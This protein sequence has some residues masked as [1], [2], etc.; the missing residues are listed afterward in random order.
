MIIKGVLKDGRQLMQTHGGMVLET[1]EQMRER[2]AE[3]ARARVRDAAPE[4][5]AACEAVMRCAR[6]EIERP[7]TERQP[8]KEAEHLVKAAIAKAKGRG[9]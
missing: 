8:W 7:V 4:L 9:P 6:G 3:E 5:L 2:Q 1:L